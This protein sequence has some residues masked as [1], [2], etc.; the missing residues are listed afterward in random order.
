MLNRTGLQNLGSCGLSNVPSTDIPFWW[1][2]WYDPSDRMEEHLVNLQELYMNLV[3]LRI[4][5]LTS[6]LSRQD[7]QG[8]A[9]TQGCSISAWISSQ[10]FW[11]SS[12][13][14]QWSSEGPIWL[15]FQLWLLNL[16]K[17][18]AVSVILLCTWSIASWREL[19]KRTPPC[20]SFTTCMR[21]CS[22]THIYIY[23]LLHVYTASLC[24]YIY[25]IVFIFICLLTYIYIY[26]IMSACYIIY[27]N[28]ITCVIMCVCVVCVVPG[29]TWFLRCFSRIKHQ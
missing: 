9:Q 10:G 18:E 25:I 27:T 22:H 28:T 15:I 14:Y 19:A 13:A 20:A 11:C 16:S 23:I 8:G 26:T 29:V 12:A 7:T 24:A 21:A 17:Q 6:Q 2:T 5:S 1:I 4:W 3:Q